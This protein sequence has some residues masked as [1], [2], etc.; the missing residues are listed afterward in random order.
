MPEDGIFWQGRYGSSFKLDSTDSVI[1]ATKF[2]SEVNDRTP[3]TRSARYVGFL[4]FSKESCGDDF[5]AKL[6][7][8]NLMIDIVDYEFVY[9]ILNY[10]MKADE[11]V[12]GFAFELLEVTEKNYPFKIRR[13][14]TSKWISIISIF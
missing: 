9:Q 5:I 2:R 4:A 3:N 7:D 6:M 10:G 14:G 8:G 12:A 1:V 11:S 13:N